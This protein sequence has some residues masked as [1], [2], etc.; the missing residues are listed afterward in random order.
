M[1]HS[2]FAR[3][4]P[5]PYMRLTLSLCLLFL[6]IS[7]LSAQSIFTGPRDYVIESYPDS[8]V[9]ADFNGDGLPDIAVAD[10][11]SANISVLLQNSNGTFQATVFYTVGNGPTSLQVGDVNGDGKPDF[12][13]LNSL[14]ATFSVLL[15]NGDGTFQAQKVTSIPSTADLANT[16]TVGNFNGDNY[17][18]V[19]VPVQLAQ[20]GT[21]GIGVL[22]G[23]GDG[24]FQPVVS[25]AL[26]AQARA[27]AAGDFNKDGKIDLVA[28]TGNLN[29]N[30]ISV[31][32]GNGDGTF[33]SA[34]D[35]S[36]TFSTLG[37][38][39]A[40]FNQ[41]GNLDI[42]A[43]A[44]TYPT[45]SVVLLYGNGNGSFQAQPP[46][47]FVGVPVT[48][49]DLN[50]DGK[51]DLVITPSVQQPDGPNTL[52]ILLNNGNGTFTQLQSLPG[53]VAALYDLLGDQ[54]LD[55]ISAGSVVS[56][57]RSNG[58]GTFA[59]FPFYPGGSALGRPT[60]MAI[61]GST[62]PSKLLL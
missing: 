38:V 57:V 7:T 17:L 11:Y 30:G 4:F 18:D 56:V 53:T 49:G 40:D 20:V 39:L 33:Q 58:D 52:Q 46:L 43:G 3:N 50:G 44:G 23:N 37:L 19:A 60:S 47:S 16:L 25:Y 24:T 2:S 54:K 28:T 10:Q 51:P 61:I 48:A 6:A 36:L 32:L 14:D 22:I 1:S 29:S 15:G 41:D 5:K 12:V 45:Y 13:V 9:V 55:L 27:V 21:F 8:V 42:A 35:T 59:T 62:S 34:I 26:S 31:L